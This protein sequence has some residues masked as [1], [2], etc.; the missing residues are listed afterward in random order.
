MREIALCSAYMLREGERDSEKLPKAAIE[1]H[2]SV[3]RDF[4]SYMA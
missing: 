1:T 3:G 2:V 4:E